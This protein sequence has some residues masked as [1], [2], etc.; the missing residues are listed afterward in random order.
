MNSLVS[1]TVWTVSTA[2]SQL[3]RLSEQFPEM[4]GIGNR[5]ILRSQC[6]GLI[7]SVQCPGSVV[8]C[9]FDAIRELRDAGVVIAGGFHSPMERECL[10]F[11]LRGKQPIVVCPAKHPNGSRLP[12]ECRKAINDGRLL[13]VSPFGSDTRVTTKANAQIRNEFVASLSSLI[14]IPHCSPGGSAEIIARQALER[15][16]TIVTFHCDDNAA[17]VQL[18]AA[19]YCLE[20][21]R[22]SF[23]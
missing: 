12:T 15:R 1:S 18:G 21:A 22:P 14:L 13:L 2:G 7:C 9:T 5:E 6:L 19:P 8:I 23:Q 11:F 4:H 17:L 16:Q 10:D 3:Q 20:S